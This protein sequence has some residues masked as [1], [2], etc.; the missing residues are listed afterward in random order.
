MSA[1]APE[2]HVDEVVV[3]SRRFCVELRS[4]G[5]GW[6]AAAR[7]ADTGEPFGPAIVDTSADGA[8]LRLTRW[9][10]WQH[11]H[12]HAIDVLREAERA[13]HRHV[14][15]RAF[16]PDPNDEMSGDVRRAALRDVETA[17]RLLDAIRATR[18]R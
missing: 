14:A 1:F 17:R 15:G 13:Y 12:A 9:L 11:G 8:R 10:H 7:C 2:R 5:G 16:A 18:P 6:T 3:G 4:E